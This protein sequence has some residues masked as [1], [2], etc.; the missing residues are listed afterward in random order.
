M[1]E[2]EMEDD[3]DT[4]MQMRM[5]MVLG[6][7]SWPEVTCPDC[8]KHHDVI[9]FA[10]TS[11]RTPPLRATP[12]CESITSLLHHALPCSAALQDSYSLTDSDSLQYCLLFAVC[13]VDAVVGKPRFSQLQN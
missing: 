7:A 4:E 10:F 9:P 6:D 12:R 8:Y 1:E 11:R 3:G 2:V 13:L 5:E